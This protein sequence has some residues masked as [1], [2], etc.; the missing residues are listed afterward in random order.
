MWKLLLVP[1]QKSITATT[2][3]LSRSRA[4][5]RL[6]ERWYSTEMRLQGP[7][8]RAKPVRQSTEDRS[9]VVKWA[10]HV[11]VQFMVEQQLRVWIPSTVVANSSGDKTTGAQYT[12]VLLIA[13]GFDN[14]LAKA[15]KL[16]RITRV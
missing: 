2:R 1:S 7:S 3:K 13:E 11:V 15:V 14:A 8:K 9:T 10:G 6:S 16:G 5:C 12:K 4:P